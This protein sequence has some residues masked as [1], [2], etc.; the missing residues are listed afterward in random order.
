M[1][2]GRPVR[3]LVARGQAGAD[4]PSEVCEHVTDRLPFA[5]RLVRVQLGQASP[6]VALGLAHEFLSLVG[7]LDDGVPGIS[8]GTAAI[9]EPRDFD[10]RRPP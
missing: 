2:P 5:G 1:R 7:E 8:L 9:S 3:S 6:E 10:A 4:R